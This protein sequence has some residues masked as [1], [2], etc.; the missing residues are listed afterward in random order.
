MSATLC[1]LFDG[2]YHLGAAVL[3]NSLH[4]AGF[5]GD[6]VAGYR[7]APPP[8]M[9]GRDTLQVGGL[10]VRL[11]PLSTTR[12]LTNYKPDFLLAQ[13][14][15][16]AA[17]LWYLDPD[18]VVTA[19]WSFF[20]E[21]LEAGVAL[22]EDVNSPLAADHPRRAGW[23]RHFGPRGF[24]LAFREPAYVNGGCLGVRA[25]HT[26]F[27]ELWRDLQLAMAEAIGGLDQTKLGG[28]TS[29]RMR[30][31]HFCFNASDQDAL[32]AAVEAAPAALRFSILGAE[33]MGFRPGRT[34]LPHAL[35]TPKPWRKHYVRESLAGRP[36]TAADK[37][38]WQFAAGP[39]AAFPA[40]LV[41][42]RRRAVALAAFLGRFYRR[43]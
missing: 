38:F 39:V 17:P 25:D 26:A 20:A 27:L 18:I 13:R 33:A 42:R 11:V 6:F 10:T 9:Q 1:T 43:A 32:N 8:W 30:D 16:T 28:G 37:A 14:A 7:G 24:T 4:A 40:G 15:T 36:P 2:D 12:H 35:G 5:A 3:I 23:R 22:C 19:P 21:W 34:V 31:P 41:T 29:T